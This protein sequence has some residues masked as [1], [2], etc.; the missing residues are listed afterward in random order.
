MKKKIQTQTDTTSYLVKKD[1]LDKETGEEHRVNTTVQ[2]RSER[3]LELSISGYVQKIEEDGDG[4][5][6]NEVF[7]EQL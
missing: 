5:E 4:E 3:G 2:L 1:F 7:T 6:E